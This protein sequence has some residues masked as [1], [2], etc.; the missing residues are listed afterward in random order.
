MA[1][2]YSAGWRATHSVD[3]LLSK[4]AKAVNGWR[5]AQTNVT[6]KKVRLRITAEVRALAIAV[7][8]R[9]NL[10]PRV[11]DALTP[12]SVQALI[13]GTNGMWPTLP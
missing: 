2:F 13:D 9:G 11:P 7:H 5:R 6:V 4:A 12:G 1:H 3:T 8:E 10:Q